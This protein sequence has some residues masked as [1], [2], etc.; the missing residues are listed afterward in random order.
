MSEASCGITPRR[1]ATAG[2]GGLQGEPGEI[3]LPSAVSTT[4]ALGLGQD[5]VGVDLIFETGKG[6]VAAGLCSSRRVGGIGP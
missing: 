1:P 5:T 6:G 2:L 3:R 4:K